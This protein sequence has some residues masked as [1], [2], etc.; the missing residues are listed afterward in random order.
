MAV[1]WVGSV[2]RSELCEGKPGFTT[3]TSQISNSLWLVFHHIEDSYHTLV[4]MTCSK[5]MSNLSVPPRGV[6]RWKET[7]NS[8]TPFENWVFLYT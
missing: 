1:E 7:V 8:S 6:C 3:K 2:S 4:R 5:L